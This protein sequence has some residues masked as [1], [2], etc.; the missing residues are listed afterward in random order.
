MHRKDFI[1]NALINIRQSMEHRKITESLTELY[2]ARIERLELELEQI[3]T[4]E[5][6]NAT[7][8]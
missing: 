2:N 3:Y 4:E 6:N 7:N 5:L 8:D 1:L